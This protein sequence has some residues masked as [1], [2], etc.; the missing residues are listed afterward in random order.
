MV[1]VAAKND[2]RMNGA[3]FIPV[4]TNLL[5]AGHWGLVTVIEQLSI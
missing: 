2:R 1:C 3:D 5:Q 4:A